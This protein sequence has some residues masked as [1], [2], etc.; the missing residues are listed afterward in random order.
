MYVST[1]IYLYAVV[2]KRN[3]KERPL[4][5]I[6]FLDYQFF[7]IGCLFG[8]CLFYTGGFE[9]FFFILPR[10]WGL[11]VGEWSFISNHTYFSSL[12]GFILSYLTL[13][14]IEKYVSQELENENE[15]Y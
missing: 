10:K 14:H 2:K 12:F 3:L 4:W 15:N 13:I 1:F 6:A 7:T 11:F 5:G 9:Y 8:L